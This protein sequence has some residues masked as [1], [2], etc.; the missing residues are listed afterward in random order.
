MRTAALLLVMVAFIARAAPPVVDVERARLEVA[1]GGVID[2]TGGCWLS[3]GR[4]VET[5]REIVSLREE[6]TRL[7]QA[8]P[9]TPTAIVV[10]I[11]VSLAL[12]VAAG[13]AV[14][15]LWR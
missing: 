5:A 10:T 9:V 11:A 13:V 1:D 8:P 3:S 2:V 14:A 12:G 7:R 4:C 6:N 15:Q